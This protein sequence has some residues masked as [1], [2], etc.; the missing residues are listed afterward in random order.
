LRRRRIAERPPETVIVPV[1]GNILPIRKAATE[2]MS[3]PARLSGT[4]EAFGGL[5]KPQQW[6]ESVS[7]GSK[8][9]RRSVKF[10]FMPRLTLRIR[11]NV[12]RICAPASIAVCYIEGYMMIRI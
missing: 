5:P 3:R 9:A 11:P 4:I 12:K 10:I 6:P 2:L 1:N 8:V 7:A